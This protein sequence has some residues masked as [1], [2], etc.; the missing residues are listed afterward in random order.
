MIGSGGKWR[1]VTLIEPY[2][3]ARIA[4]A[5]NLAA[6]HGYDALAF[7]PGP[8]FVYLT[9]L[10]FHLM[11]RP[12]LLVVTAHGDVLGLI[13]ELERLKWS[14]AFPDAT[15][16]WWQDSDG[17]EAAF[18]GL[19]AEF[20]PV[21]LGVEGGRMRLF[22]G[23]ALRR[24]LPTDAVKDAD[25]ALAL[26]RIEKDDGEIALLSKAIAISEAAFGETCEAVRPGDTE[27][28]I[29]ARLM[30]AMLA[31]GADGFSFSPIVLA[32][33]KSANPH[34]T[35]DDT[36]LQPGDALLIDFGARVAG[37][38]AD[39]TRTAFCGHVS[40]EHAAIYETVLAANAAGR[41][42]ARPGMTC[43]DLDVATTAVLKA[44][45]FADLV[46]HKT[47]HGL[48]LDVHEAPHVMIGNHFLLTPGMVVTIEPGLYRAGEIGVRIEDD[49][50]MEKTGA[51]SLSGFDRSLKVL[52]G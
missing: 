37:F 24:H 44:S 26:L 49:V 13:P 41:E 31:H 9:G 22:E 38:N 51:R 29:A 32:G 35:P 27:R 18:A 7:V 40:D 6:T 3:K 43:H 16:F 42:A 15:T 10:D 23:E 25:G 36:P 1:P 46:V 50:V 11:E 47:G 20:G 30:Q 12:T 8:N 14:A 21:A 45:P 17:F 2:M 4:R 39:I 19:A 52:G 33:G 5:A 48:G 34:G 28:E